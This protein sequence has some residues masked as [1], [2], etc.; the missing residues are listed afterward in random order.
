MRIMSKSV[1]RNIPRYLM[2]LFWIGIITLCF[3][4]RDKI[5]VEQIVNFTPK[6]PAIA[7]LVMLVLFA[8]KSVV[9]F[10]Y[11]GILYAASGIIFPLPKAIVVNTLGTFIM[12]VIP[13]FIGKKAGKDVLAKLLA[14]N[15]KLELLRDTSNKNGFFVSF[16]VRI[17]GLLPG[18]LVGM[19]LGA[20]GV[21][22]GKYVVGTMLGLYPAIIAFS[23]MGMSANDPTSPTFIISAATEIGL[24]ILSLIL[25][26]FWSRRKKK[27]SSKQIRTESTL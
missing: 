19:Y 24:C 7:A 27:K 25:Y 4:N 13:Y 1:C 12:T 8:V 20:S 18:D 15:S 2:L 10:V 3:F 5:S 14:K 9:V 26:I 23:V 22:F 11:G 17:V 21:G 6:E 16:F